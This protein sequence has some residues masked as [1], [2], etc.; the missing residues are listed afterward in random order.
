MIKSAVRRALSG[1]F[2]NDS[3]DW[4]SIAGAA[5]L[6]LL[7]ALWRRRGVCA[8]DGQIDRS[9]EF[10]LTYFDQPS[11]HRRRRRVGP[12]HRQLACYSRRRPAGRSWNT[13][14]VGDVSLLSAVASVHWPLTSSSTHCLRRR[15]VHGVDDFF[16]DVV[17]CA[18]FAGSFPDDLGLWLVTV[19]FRVVATTAS[20]Y[21]GR[22]RASALLLLLPNRPCTSQRRRPTIKTITVQLAFARWQHDVLLTTPLPLTTE[23]VFR[24][25]TP[26]YCRRCRRRSL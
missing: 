26:R 25:R 21:L 9:T 24:F 20:R 8:Q 23:L 14:A 4:K 11:A 3:V 15:S 22:H 17:T 7:L 18:A 19:A 6:L 12:S 2:S 10:I 1:A 13:V 5:M 16:L